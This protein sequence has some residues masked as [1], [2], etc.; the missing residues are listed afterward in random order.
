MTKPLFAGCFILLLLNVG[1]VEC[2]GHRGRDEDDD[3]EY[4]LFVFGDAAADTG[5]SPHTGGQISQG[6]RAWYYPY[7]ISDDDNDNRPSGRFSDGLVQSDFL[8][9]ILGY[10]ESPP[11]FADYR[12]RRRSNS[13]DP[14]GMNFANASAGVWYEVPKVSE[15]VDQFTRLVNDGA[16]TREDLEDSVALVAVSGRDYWRITDSNDNIYTGMFAFLVTEEMVRVVKHL[17]DAGVGK[18]L[19]NT[20]PPLGCTPATAR[21]AGYGRCDQRGN[22]LSDAHN[23]YL[24]EKLGKKDG[25]L[26]LDVHA[27]VNNLLGS[28]E[29]RQQRSRPCCEARDA[30]NG[31]CGQ[32]GGSTMCR[33]P[34]DYFYWDDRNP[35]SAGWKAV[36][37]QLQTPVMDFLGIQTRNNL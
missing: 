6:S 33:D 22:D 4:K 12:P 26:L 8:A 27:A 5:N 11:P 18:V 36:M 29:F 28:E 23:K 7:G 35:T 30:R 3:P 24:N 20:L 34:E 21:S 16:I 31:Y 1:D 19:V 2:R 37:Q 14:S 10:D 17:Q 9:R 32:P 25:V 13:V 15:Q